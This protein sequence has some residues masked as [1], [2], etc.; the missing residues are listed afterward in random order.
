MSKLIETRAAYEK[1]ARLLDQE[2]QKRS[3]STKDLER[4]REA[5]DVAF[6]MLGWAQFEHLVREETKELIDKKA[7]TKTVEKH[8]WAYLKTRVA[9]IPV[10]SRL[11]LVFHAN[12]A[13]IEALKKDYGIRNAATHNYKTLPSSV[14]D[15]SAWLEGLQDL[16]DRF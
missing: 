8:A 11:E 13:A 12:P 3:G 2:I 15:V 16:V 6:Y 4:N 10:V 14:K 7:T 5:L 1:L 9:D